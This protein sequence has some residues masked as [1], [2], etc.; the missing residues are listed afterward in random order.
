MA[1]SLALEEVL[2]SY[3]INLLLH[4]IYFL[5]VSKNYQKIITFCGDFS[6][7]ACPKN[8]AKF[9]D[10]VGG[11]TVFLMLIGGLETMFGLFNKGIDSIILF[12]FIFTYWSF[13]NSRRV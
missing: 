10:F 11:D 2:F 5:L 8:C 3:Q 7:G 12:Y 4:P 6:F 9:A 1:F 13:R